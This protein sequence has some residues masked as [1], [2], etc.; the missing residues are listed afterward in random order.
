MAGHGEV[1][2]NLDR[3]LKQAKDATMKIAETGAT[4]AENNAKSGYRWEDQTYQ[5]SNELQGS[6]DWEGDDAV[7]IL[8][9]GAQHGLYLELA[10]GR[11]YAIIEDSLWKAFIS[12][13][14][15]WKRMLG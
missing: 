7:M 12:A 14:R 10:H 4:E 9:H 5:A 1:N 8:C 15:T 13:H 3:W 6:A 2:R 11:K